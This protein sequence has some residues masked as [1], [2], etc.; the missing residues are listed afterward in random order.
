MAWLCL[1]SQSR[2]SSQASETIIIAGPWTFSDASQKNLL[3]YAH[4]VEGCSV[5]QFTQDGLS[6]QGGWDGSVCGSGVPVTQAATDLA[7]ERLQDFVFIGL[8]ERWDIS[9][10]LLHAQFGGT[11]HGLELTSFNSL[12]ASH[13][14]YDTAPLR[15]WVDVYDGQLYA[16]AVRIFEHRL[17]EYG[18]SATSCEP[19]FAHRPIG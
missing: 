3:E 7:V 12:N 2:G 19:C 6:Y 9:V 8:Q 13:P 11:C 18:V 10:C 15:G 1:D 5:K 4:R 16:E 17:M 14:P